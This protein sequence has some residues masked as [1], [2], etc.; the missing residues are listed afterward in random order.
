MIAYQLSQS[1]LTN[2]YHSTRLG[3][4]QY[5]QLHRQKYRMAQF[6]KIYTQNILI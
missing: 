6:L 1:S 2:T 5:E 4:G 3:Q